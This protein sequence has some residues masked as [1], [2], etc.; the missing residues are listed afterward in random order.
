MAKKAYIGVDGIARKI[1]K[2]Y[3]GVDGIARK[4]KKAYIGIGGVARPCWSSGLEYYGTIDPLPQDMTAHAATTVGQYGMLF[5]GIRNPK[6]AIAYNKSLT[7]VPV[8]GLSVERKTRP[9]ATKVGSYAVVGGGTDYDGRFESYDTSLTHQVSTYESPIKRTRLA[10]T[11][12]GNRGMF[13]GGRSGSSDTDRVDVCDASLTFTAG[14]ALRSARKNPAAT[15][16][17]GFALVAGGGQYS[18]VV[19]TYDES[20]TR[21]DT[22]KNL[23]KARE[24]LAATTVKKCALFFGGDTSSTS[25]TNIV[26]AYDASLTRID[27]VE[28]LSDTKTGPAATTLEDFAICAGGLKKISGQTS[29][30][31]VASVDAYDASLVRQSAHPLSVARGELA[32]YTLESFAV[33]AGG[34]MGT[35]ITSDESFTAVDVYTA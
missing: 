9:A 34:S 31:S 32:A 13:V 2:G 12:F 11:T 26:D 33:F 15:T 19:D 8:D 28:N 30:T 22:T 6:A 4:I 7:V 29:F 18:S 17:E 14:R 23:R 5:G 24:M 16:V 21:I 10:A 27:T 20:I 25:D 35:N 3:V 1:K